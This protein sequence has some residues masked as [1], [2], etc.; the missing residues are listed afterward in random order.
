MTQ[1]VKPNINE[2]QCQYAHWRLH[3]FSCHSCI[4]TGSWP[5]IQKTNKKHVVAMMCKHKYDVQPTG[6]GRL[7]SWL[8]QFLSTPSKLHH[9]LSSSSS[10]LSSQVNCIHNQCISIIMIIKIITVITMG[11]PGAYITLKDCIGSETTIFIGLQPQQNHQGRAY[12]TDW[13]RKLRNG[14]HIHIWSYDHMILTWRILWMLLSHPIMPPL[15]GCHMKHRHTTVRDC[16]I[17]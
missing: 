11:N 14:F 4:A 12:T 5:I 1:W 2:L 3:I 7:S 15:I 10:S 8:V 16:F 13:F 17:H 6:S 9:L